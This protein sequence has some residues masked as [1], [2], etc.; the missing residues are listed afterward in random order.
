MIKE[1]LKE[2]F[3]KINS[4]KK[5][6]SNSKMEEELKNQRDTIRNL[7]ELLKKNSFKTLMITTREDDKE[8]DE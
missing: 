2:L 5:N 7:E 1:T 6:S 4:I 8:K 3:G